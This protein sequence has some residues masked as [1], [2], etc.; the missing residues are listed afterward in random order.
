MPW[1]NEGD[2]SQEEFHKSW[3]LITSSLHRGANNSIDDSQQFF[4]PE[5]QLFPTVFSTH[6]FLYREIE[7][8]FVCLLVWQGNK[9]SKFEATVN[10]TL[11]VDNTYYL[12]CQL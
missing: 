2:C 6:F 5:T 12:T 3:S 4:F 8:L 1:K 11:I 7:P 9:L 10:D